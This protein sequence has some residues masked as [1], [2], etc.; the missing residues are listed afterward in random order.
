MEWSH[1]VRGIIETTVFSLLGIV[2]M[3]IGF[4]IVKLFTPFSI[5]KE[6]EE[7]QN[8]SLAIIIGSIILGISIIVASVVGAPT[9][10]PTPDSNKAMHTEAKADVKADAAKPAK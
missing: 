8:I 2:L 10:Q 1:V 3:G 7:D 6:I 9:S 5:K 4:F